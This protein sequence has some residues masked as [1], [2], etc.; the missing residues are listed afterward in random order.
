MSSLKKNLFLSVF[1]AAMSASVAFAADLPEP[2]II[3]YEPEAPI[4]IGSGWYLRGDMGLSAYTGGKGSWVNAYGTKVKFHD[5]DIENGW[6]AGVGVGY[7]FDE[8]FRADLTADY[9]SKVKYKAK[10]PCLDPCNHA[11]DDSSETTDFSAW[12]LMLNGYYDLTTWGAITPYVGAGAGLAYV[13]ASDYTS[14]SGYVFGDDGKTNF[15]WNLMAGAA[16]D[17][18]DNLKLDAN[19]RFMSFGKAQSDVPTSNSTENPAKYE[20]LYAHQFRVG[21]RYDLN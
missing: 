12:T 14:T 3:E 21:L 4:A 5:G 16:F 10:A 7:Y 19:Y 17:V 1:G 8:H 6:L 11:L 13:R 9:H 18:S 15:A 2:P 20:D